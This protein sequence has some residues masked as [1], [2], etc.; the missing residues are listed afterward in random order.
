M[1]GWSRPLMESMLKSMFLYSVVSFLQLWHKSAT[2]DS[3]YYFSLPHA[4]RSLK[5]VKGSSAHC[6]DRLYSNIFYYMG[7]DSACESWWDTGFGLSWSSWQRDFCS[8]TVH[9]CTLIA[10]TLQNYLIWKHRSKTQEITGSGIRMTWKLILHNC[11]RNISLELET[12]PKTI[13]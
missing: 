2:E 1:R 8:V 5:T 10:I 12:F 4:H 9:S 3:A 7:W 13:V 11:H 6:E